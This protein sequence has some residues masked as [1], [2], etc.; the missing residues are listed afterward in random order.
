M[1]PG[2]I[3][4]HHHFA[5]AALHQ[6]SVDCTPK[7]TPGIQA[8]LDGIRTARKRGSDTITTRA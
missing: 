1:V 8:I 4:A 3:D 2:F 6:A 5:Q 7:S